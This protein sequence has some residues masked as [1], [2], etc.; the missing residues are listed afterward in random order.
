VVDSDKR[1]G[2]NPWKILPLPNSKE[3]VYKDRIWAAEAGAEVLSAAKALEVVAGAFDA[4]S[5]FS[6]AFP[7]FFAGFGD[8][9][10]GELHYSRPKLQ[11]SRWTKSLTK[12]NHPLLYSRRQ[13]SQGC[14]LWSSLQ[15]S[16]A[17]FVLR[18][19]RWA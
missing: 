7:S 5:S 14:H 19:V 10:A 13:I 6:C 17:A 9:S 16:C 8:R 15:M 18:R 1:Q 12:K 4:A 3:K 2:G 11:V